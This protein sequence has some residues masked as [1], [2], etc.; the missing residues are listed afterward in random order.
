M[1][2]KEG[3]ASFLK[4]KICLQISRCTCQCPEF[5]LKGYTRHW[6]WC[7]IAGGKRG[8]PTQARQRKLVFTAYS[9]LDFI[10]G[11]PG[12]LIASPSA[13]KIWQKHTRLP[14][15]PNSALWVPFTLFFLPLDPSAA[16]PGR[17]V[18]PSRFLISFGLLWS[19]VKIDLPCPWF[20][21]NKTT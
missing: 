4:C 20:F 8:R 21:W 2:R 6:E 1:G 11:K 17:Q 13:N 9:D 7:N 3:G 19:L 18:Y 10:L 12:S 5:I 14:L 15:L 16:L